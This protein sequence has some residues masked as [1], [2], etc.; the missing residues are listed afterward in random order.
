MNDKQF[1]MMLKLMFGNGYLESYEVI[2]NKSGIRKAGFR[3]TKVKEYPDGDVDYRVTINKNILDRWLGEVND[4]DTTKHKLKLLLTKGG[5][6]ITKKQ[7]SQEIDELFYI[8]QNHNDALV[9]INKRL[10]KLFEELKE[11]KSCTC[12]KPTKIKVKATPGRPKKVKVKVKTTKQPR[13]KDGK[14]AK[15]K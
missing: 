10:D 11:F 13:S 15:K 7:L 3:S 9:G 6:M 1:I 2:D 4:K 8:V 5:I 14:F 12:K